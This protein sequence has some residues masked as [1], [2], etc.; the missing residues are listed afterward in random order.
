[1]A[2]ATSGPLWKH[3]RFCW[4][5]ATNCY[6]ILARALTPTSI[7]FLA[8]RVYLGVV[9]VLAAALQH[10][11]TDARVAAL[12]RHLPTSRTTLARWREWW[13]ATFPAGP[14]W[15]TFRARFAPP[16]DETRLPASA[17]ERFAGDLADR[18]RFFLDF[19]RPISS[20]PSPRKLAP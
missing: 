19:L 3:G 16:V 2:L 18:L 5:C 4:S 20:P 11:L 15:Q 10:G 6:L 1:M 7:R 9:V 17:L 12:Q 13:L 8:R 14:F